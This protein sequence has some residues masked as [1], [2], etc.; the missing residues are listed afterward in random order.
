MMNQELK[1]EAQVEIRP[2]DLFV[3][4]EQENEQE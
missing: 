2:E 1:Q 3:D 4:K